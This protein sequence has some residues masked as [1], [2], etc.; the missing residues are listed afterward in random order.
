MSGVEPTGVAPQRAGHR[1]EALGD[2]IGAEDFHP[3]WGCG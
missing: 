3:V 2:H 1:Q